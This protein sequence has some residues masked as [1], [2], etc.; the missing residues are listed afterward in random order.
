MV[1]KNKALIV[2]ATFLTSNSSFSASPITGGTLYE[3]CRSED[4]YQLGTCDGYIF[5]V[6]D[7]MHAGHLSNHFAVCMPSGITAAQLRLS[8]R[9][10][11]EEAPE[12]LQFLADGKV[13]E[14]LAK[15]FPCKNT[16]EN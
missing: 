7:A 2:L 3:L 16:E 9:K 12:N 14:A 1:I 10:H 13:A 4:Q 11:M 8:V 5:G 6:I 15:Y